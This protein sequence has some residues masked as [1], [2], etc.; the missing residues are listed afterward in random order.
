MGRRALRHGHGKGYQGAV[1]RS[2]AF[3]PGKYFYTDEGEGRATMRLNYTMAG[4]REI[5]RAVKILGR[6][7][8]MQRKLAV[9]RF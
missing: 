2:T 1:D 8:Q 6:K 3:V 7:S 9:V 5:R 4:E